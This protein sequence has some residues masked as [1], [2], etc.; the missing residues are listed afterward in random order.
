MKIILKKQNHNFIG[1]QATRG[2]VLFLFPWK[3]TY[4]E[5]ID[6]LRFCK[7]QLKFNQFV[8]LTLF[9][10][11]TLVCDPPVF[12]SQSVLLR[13]ISILGI[14]T[15]TLIVNPGYFDS[16]LNRLPATAGVIDLCSSSLL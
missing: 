5:I 14:K 9:L 15:G 11:D 6:P 4:V 8:H 3:G 2:Q 1:G 12:I 7:N 16:I 13:N 10:N